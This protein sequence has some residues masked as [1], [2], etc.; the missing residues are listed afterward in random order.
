[1]RDN[2]ILYKSLFEALDEVEPAL[3]KEVMQTVYRYAMNDTQPV[4]TGTALALFKMVKPLIDSNNKKYEC[5]KMGG[6]PRKEKPSNNQ[7]ETNQKPNHNQTITNAEPFDNLKDKSKKIKDK[8]EMLK[9]NSEKINDNSEMLKEKSEMLK[10]NKNTLSDKSD[11]TRPVYPYREIIEH[12]NSKAGTN[13]RVNSK[14]TRKHIKARFDEGFTV[15]DFKT[16]IDHKVTEWG[17][18][19]DMAQYLRPSTLFGTKFESY[20]NQKVVKPSQAKSK[21]KFCNFPQR[22]YDWD[23]LEAEML[24]KGLGEV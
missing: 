8:S 17:N 14:D 20:L 11:S 5:G 22:E 10:D 21:N 7:T 1:M 9:D 12:L 3:Y 4:C 18:N 24:R 15:E 23:N 2:I 6:R 19:P 13:F 16:V